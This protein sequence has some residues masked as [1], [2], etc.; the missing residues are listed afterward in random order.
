PV[1]GVEIVAERPDGARA[2]LMPFPTPLRNAKG[3]LIGAV[4]MLVDT[5]PLKR[6]EAA[7][8]R[9]ADEQA[10]LY[11]FTDRLHRAETE[12]Q[13]YGAA[14]DAILV[15]LGCSRA[16]V[17]LFDHGGVMRFVAARGLSKAYRDA[18]EGH[19]PWR[20]GDAYPAPICIEDAPASGALDD[21]LKATLVAEGIGALAFIPVVFEGGV[22]GKFM[23]YYDEPHA[24][25]AREIDLALNIS[26]QLGFSVHRRSAEDVR[27]K[28]ISIVEN[29]DDAIISKNLDGVIVSWNKGAERVFGYTAEEIVG[30]PVTTLMPPELQGEE[31]GI[32]RRIRSGERIEHYETIRV[33]KDGVRIYISLTVSPVK[34]GAG[35]IVG[36]AKIARDITERRRSEEQRTLLINELNHR[37]KN[38]LATV[39]SLAMQTLRAPSSDAPALFQARLGALSRAHD[40]LTLEHWQGADIASVIGRALTPFQSGESR[41]TIAGPGAYLSPK[42][43]LAL[44]IALHE[45]ATNAA[46]YGALSSA[47]GRV[48]VAWSHTDGQLKLTWSESGGPRVAPPTRTGFGARL[49]ERNLAF[50]LGGDAGIE[51]RPEGVMAHLSMPLGGE[52]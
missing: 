43:A 15:G 20:P 19:S 9:R 11:R 8:A 6:A 26:R 16:A 3:E 22:I 7:L 25:E 36:A 52:G 1:R 47:G 50:E 17:L 44:T 32:L 37:V 24:F 51:Y 31:P 23:A 34:D 21:A 13:V 30:K 33:R 10:V 18:V 40:L 27:Q 29:S 41:F 42:Q 2:P 14:L 49:I 48:D 4:N 12:E 39:Q 45:L 35:N 46:K 28:L 38:T 5:A